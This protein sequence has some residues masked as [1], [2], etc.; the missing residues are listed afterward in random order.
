MVGIRVRD[1]HKSTFQC[2]ACIL[3]VP[4]FAAVTTLGVSVPFL[5]TNLASYFVGCRLRSTT[6]NDI[7]FLSLHRRSSARTFLFNY[8]SLIIGGRAPQTDLKL[9][10]NWIFS[11]I[12]L[13]NIWKNP[14]KLKFQIRLGSSNW[15][16]AYLSPSILAQPPFLHKRKTNPDFRG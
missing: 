6:L 8:M 11:S 1:R 16:Y 14:I 3:I 7:L 13:F 9:G 12:N 4:M 2:R 5:H 10:F 15:R